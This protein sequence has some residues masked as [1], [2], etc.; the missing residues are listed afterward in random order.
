MMIE[1][2]KMSRKVQW[3]TVMIWLNQGNKDLNLAPMPFGAKL[4]A[5]IQAVVDEYPVYFPGA[6]KLNDSNTK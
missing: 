3:A 5:E 4:I 1:L 6:N 2:E